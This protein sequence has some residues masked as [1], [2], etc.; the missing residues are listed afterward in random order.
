MIK[1]GLENLTL[2]RRNKLKEVGENKCCEETGSTT[3]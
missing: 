3:A 2:T 1:D